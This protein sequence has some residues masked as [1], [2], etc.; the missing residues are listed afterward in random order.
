M[1]PYRST[2]FLM[3]V[4]IVTSLATPIVADAQVAGRAVPR[5]NG[6]RAG[7][8]RQ[9]YDRGYEEGLR[10]GEQDARRNRA[11]NARLDNRLAYRDDFRRGFADGYRSG[12]DA[13]RGS[14]YRP[15]GGNG[16]G[17]GATRR[18]PGSNQEPAFARGY[19]DGY[20]EGLRDFRGRD[21]YDPVGTRD[22]RNA[23]QG[24]YGSYGSRD[25]Y[26][27]NYRAGFRQGYEEGYRSGR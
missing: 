5:G 6:A 16:P 3:G 23:D 1:G 20:E 19:A 9:G 21:R 18:M 2:R 8:I 7:Q 24:Y 10:R 25:A 15:F 13:I 12:F 17:L 27:N 4:L 11:F 14:S 26:K 22:Y